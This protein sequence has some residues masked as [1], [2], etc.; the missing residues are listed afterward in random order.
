MASPNF[1]SRTGFRS[2]CERIPV[3]YVL[4]IMAWLAAALITGCR[5]NSGSTATADTAQAVARNVVT[6]AD[7]RRCHEEIYRAWSAS[8]H[9]HAHRPVVATADAGAFQQIGRASCRE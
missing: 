8:H 1:S 2:S 9:A 3:V 6:S 7:C 5:R 4:F